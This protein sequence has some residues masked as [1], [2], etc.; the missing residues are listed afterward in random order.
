MGVF[1][2]GE[3]GAAAEEFPAGEG[4]E[5]GAGGFAAAE[6]FGALG[7]SQS[8]RLRR[9]Q[10]AARWP[11]W[12]AQI[13]TVSRTFSAS[14]RRGALATMAPVRWPVRRKDLEKE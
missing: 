5:G 1:D 11:S 13:V 10:R 12:G 4:G 2:V 9:P 8:V 6:D 3:V 7:A 14:A